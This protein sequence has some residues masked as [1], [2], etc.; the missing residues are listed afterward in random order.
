MAKERR[1]MALPPFGS[2]YKGEKGNN[3]DECP[4]AMFIWDT[5][6]TAHVQ[7]CDALANQEFGR[8]L[9]FALAHRVLHETGPCPRSQ[10]KRRLAWW[11]VQ[12]VFA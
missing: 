9:Y 11:E 2:L 8:D 12:F 3:L 5:Q 6:K 7:P 4:G 1:S 10:L